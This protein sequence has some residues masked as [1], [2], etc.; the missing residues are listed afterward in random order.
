NEGLPGW[1]LDDH[2]E[3]RKV[4]WTGGAYSDAGCETV[5]SYLHPGFLA[6]VRDRFAAA[7]EVIRPFL[8]KNGGRKSCAGWCSV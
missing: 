3:I 4:Y 6:L 2:P 7:A 5:V 1:V 8:A